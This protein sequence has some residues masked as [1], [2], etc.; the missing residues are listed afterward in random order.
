MRKFKGKR[1]VAYF[2]VLGFKAK[3]KSQDLQTIVDQYEN[4]IKNTDGQIT[5]NDESKAYYFKKVCYRYIFSDSIFLIA[6]EDTEESF[7][8]MLSY[9][10]RMMQ[11]SI[12]FGYPLRGA[13]VYGDV[14]VDTEKNIYVGES[15]VDAVSLEGAQDWIGAIV[16]N[17]VLERYSTVFDDHDLGEMHSLILQEY[18]VPYKNGSL[19]KH[20]TINWRANMNS[21]NGIKA[22]FKNESNNEAVK[23]KIDNTLQ[24]CK[25]LRDIGMV[26]TDRESTPMQYRYIFIGKESELNDPHPVDDGY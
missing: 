21:H 7:Y 16:D 19:H 11:L 24:Y 22:L 20:T 12:A 18:D 14:Y 26:Y 8:E 9:A 4:L 10:W 1:A 2:D 25:H 17:S 23:V 15:I 6:N 13:M 5:F 3:I